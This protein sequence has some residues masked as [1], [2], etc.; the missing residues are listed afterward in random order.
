AASEQELIDA[1]A[2]YKSADPQ[3]QI[4]LVVHFLEKYPQSKLRS[5]AYRYMV[6]AF[7]QLKDYEQSEAMGRAALQEKPDNMTVMAELCRMASEASQAGVLIYNEFGRECG[8]KLLGMVDDHAIPYEYSDEDWKNRPDLFIGG[9]HKSL[10]IIGWYQSEASEAIQEFLEATRILPKDPYS[11]YMLAKCQ[12]K[13]IADAEAKER[14]EAAKSP[15]AK[16]PLKEKPAEKSLESSFGGDKLDALMLN[17]AREF[18]L[19][20]QAEFQ[21]LRYSVETELQFFSQNLKL[22]KPID[23]YIQS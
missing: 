16:K 10:G 7:I 14:E 21:W 15:K 3:Q 6:S 5:I 23:F 1:K 11:F 22:A 19:T 9:L 4:A 8:K 13:E 18:L 20:E 17:L 2:I 12:Y